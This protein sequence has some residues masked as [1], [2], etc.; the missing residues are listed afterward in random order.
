M[1]LYRENELPKMHLPRECTGPF[2]DSNDL[3]YRL[4]LGICSAEY[5]DVSSLGLV[6]S[7]YYVIELSVR[8]NVCNYTVE[9]SNFFALAYRWRLIS[10][11]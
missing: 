9:Q 10:L 2:H 3:Y 1:R 7:G 8:G 5:N 11:V 6:V 4:F